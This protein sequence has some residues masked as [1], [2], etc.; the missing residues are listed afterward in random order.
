M[1]NIAIVEDE[2]VV[3]INIPLARAGHSVVAT[4]DGRRWLAR[5][6]AEDCGLPFPDIFNADD[7]CDRNPVAAHRR[8]PL[9]PIIMIS[10][11]PFHPAP[12]PCF[13]TKATNPG[14]G[15]IAQKPAALLEPVANRLE[16]AQR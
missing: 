16:A 2:N 9:V 10:G 13:P 15:S 1:A 4:R 5:F 7:G 3:R 12:T 6:G 11:D 14:P 8:R